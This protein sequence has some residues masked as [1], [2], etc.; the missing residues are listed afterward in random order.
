MVTLLTWT[1]HPASDMRED[2]P[3]ED[4]SRLELLFNS[5]VDLTE[6]ERKLRL[7]K[8]P[9]PDLALASTLESLLAAHDSEARRVEQ[10]VDRAFARTPRAVTGGYV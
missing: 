3:E 1:T 10:V 9:H 7:K 6:E 5:L 8:P 4:W 2:M